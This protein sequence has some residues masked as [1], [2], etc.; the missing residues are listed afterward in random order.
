MSLGDEVVFSVGTNEVGNLVTRVVVVGRLGLIGI[1]PKFFF[2]TGIFIDFSFEE[3]EDRE[4]RLEEEER[5][6]GLLEVI[7]GRVDCSFFI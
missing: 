7:L 2:I 4:C 5:E 1:I 6:E 3:G